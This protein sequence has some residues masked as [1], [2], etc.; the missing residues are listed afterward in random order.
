MR[1]IHQASLVLLLAVVAQACHSPDGRQI[2]FVK[3]PDPQFN[4]EI[5]VMASDGS[6]AT[7]LT[8][9]PGTDGFPSWSPDGRH[10]A[11]QS[12]RDGNPEIYVTPKST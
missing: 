2:A 8:N 10:I 1:C 4:N 5:Y 6:G 9:S 7:R 12:P 3:N 11:F